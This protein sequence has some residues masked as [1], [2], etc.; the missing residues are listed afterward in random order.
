MLYTRTC[1]E[2]F[3]KETCTRVLFIG[4]SYT[5]ENDLPGMFAEL[6]RSGGHQVETGM[7]AQG[8]WSF[9][10]HVKSSTTLDIL[11]SKK[12][13]FVILQEQS[14][15]PA[16]E[17]S[18]SAS[19]YPAARE[20][21][22]QIREVSAKPI[23]FLTW[24]HRDGSPDFGISGYESMQYQINQGYLAIGQELN[25]RIAPAGY[26]WMM[27]GRQ[28][29]SLNLWQKDGSHPNKLGTY[30]AACV[31]Y[32]VIFRHSPEGLTYRS[33]IPE[34][35]AHLLQKIAAESVL[36]NPEEWNLK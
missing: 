16:F 2:L 25:A 27:A 33:D 13:D 32:A 24:A 11:K 30:L 28:N 8:G 34:D 31:F 1:I 6:S 22:S 21:V 19:M 10:D 14:E 9:A 15:I 29:L 4:N 5:F 18:R 17:Q 23:F 36:N 7:S 3:G 26:A 35:T 12:W 20:L